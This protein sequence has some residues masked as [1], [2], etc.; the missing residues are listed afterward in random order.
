MLS[1]GS[2]IPE[3]VLSVQ[4]GGFAVTAHKHH[5][6]EKARMPGVGQQMF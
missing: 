1:G 3:S 2:H 5:T 4:E 6:E